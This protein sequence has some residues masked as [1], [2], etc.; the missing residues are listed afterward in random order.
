MNESTLIQ[1]RFMFIRTRAAIS[2]RAQLNLVSTDLG[3]DDEREEAILCEF[4]IFHA[5]LNCSI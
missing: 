2:A 3:Y 1:V 4:L 5:Q